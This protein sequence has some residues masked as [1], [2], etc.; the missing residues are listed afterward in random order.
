MMIA[1]S[2]ILAVVTIEGND[3][4]NGVFS[5]NSPSLEV[6][7]EESNIGEWSI[8]VTVLLYNL[9]KIVTLEVIR[10]RGLFGR[11]TVLYAVERNGSDGIT[12]K[13]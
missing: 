8:K 10:T 9:F 11:V 5:F 4:E 7:V 12:I 13:I 1:L 3:D 6:T 2:C